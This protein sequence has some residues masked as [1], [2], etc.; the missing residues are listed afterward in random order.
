MARS[1]LRKA[2]TEATADDLQERVC[3]II[4]RLREGDP[5]DMATA[6]ALEIFLELFNRT[7]LDWLEVSRYME[8]ARGP[9]LL[10]FAPD[11]SCEAV[12]TVNLTDHPLPDSEVWLKGCRS[13][14][15]V[16]KTLEEARVVRVTGRRQRYGHTE[17]IHAELLVG[18]PSVEELEA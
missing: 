12:A 5:L 3:E 17:A 18:A 16:R 15:G 13:L 14:E 2:I 8:G 6:Q 9:A 11:G 10:I 4:G 7:S 1:P